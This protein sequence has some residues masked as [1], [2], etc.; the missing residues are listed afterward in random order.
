MES[1]R[2]EQ[3]G[4]GEAKASSIEATDEEILVG[5]LHLSQT[6]HLIYSSLKVEGRRAGMHHPTVQSNPWELGCL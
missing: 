3:G 6:G 4:D 1:S 5:K 2:R